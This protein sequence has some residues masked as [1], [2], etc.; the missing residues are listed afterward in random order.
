MK[1]L[2]IR[3]KDYSTH[4]RHRTF[5][6]KTCK[7]INPFFPFRVALMFFFLVNLQIHSPIWSFEIIFSSIRTRRCKL[8]LFLNTIKITKKDEGS[9]NK[10]KNTVCRKMSWAQWSHWQK[11]CTSLVWFESGFGDFEEFA[12]HPLS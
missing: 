1:D 6:C 10:F 5:F 4:F 7:K 2:T 11:S 9:I 8:I 12:E 3:Q